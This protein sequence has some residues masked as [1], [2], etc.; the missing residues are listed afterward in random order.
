VSRSPGTRG[1]RLLPRILLTAG[2][3]VLL[4]VGVTAYFLK[5]GV[6]IDYVN[7]G[8][9]A[10][11]DCSLIWK[12]KLE[13]QVSEISARQMGRSTGNS[14]DINFVR[15]AIQGAHYLARLFSRFSIERLNLGSSHFT[16]DLRQQSRFTHV[17]TLSSD[18]LAFESLLTFNKETLDIDIINGRN[19]RF[20]TDFKGS[21]QLDG[22]NDRITGAIS[23]LINGS[24]PVSVD[25]VADNKELRFRGREAGEITEIGPLVDLFGLSHNIQRW[26]TEYLSGSRYQLLSF[27][28]RMPW[29]SPKE[30]L[31]TL[32]A[33]VRVDDTEYTFAPG[34]EPIKARYTNVYFQQGVLVI[35]PHDATFYGQDGGESWLDINFNDPQNILLTAYIKTRAVA[36][37]DILTLLDYYQIHLPFK[38]VEGKTAADLQLAIN[39]NKIQVEVEGFFEIDQG[40]IEW[41]AK[42]FQAEDARI[43]L[44]NSDVAIKRLTIG[45]G[46]IFTAQVAGTIQARDGTGDLDVIFDK[47]IL[48][49][50]GPRVGLDPSDPAKVRYRFDADGH[51]LE[52]QPS[53]WLLD[54]M[55]IKLQK[56]TG[57]VFLDDLAMD[58]A[59]VELSIESGIQAEISGYISLRKKEV[60]LVCDLLEYQVNDLELISSL[61]PIDIEY[62]KGLVIRTEA[63]SLWKMSQMPMTLYP[64]VFAYHDHE[65]RIERSRISYGSLFDSYLYGHYNTESKKGLFSLQEIDVTNV[66][67]YRELEL[68][69]NADVEVSGVGGKFV[70]YFPHFDLRITSDEYKN[71]SAEFG[72][73]STIYSRSE[74]LRKF[75]IKEGSL[76]VSSEYGA[77]PYRFSADITMPYPLLVE[78]GEPIER[79]KV[80]GR[81][82]DEG[83]F[84]TVSENLDIAYRDSHLALSSRRIGYNINAILE[85]LRDFPLA[86][87]PSAAQPQSKQPLLIELHAEDSQVYLSPQSRLLADVIKLKLVDGKV[88]AS[89]EHGPGQAQLQF[90]NGTFL[91][92]SSDLNDQFM[93]ALVKNSRFQ[94]GRMSMAASGSFDDFSIVFEVLDTNISGLA[95]VNNVMAFLNT[96]PALMTLSLPEYNTE[97]LPIDSAVAGMRFIEKVGTFESLKVKGPEL[98]VIGNG[99]LDFSRRLINMDIFIKTQASKNVGK[100]PLIGYVLTGDDEDA[101]LSLNISGGFDDPEVGNSLVQEIVVYPVEVL[102]RTL[103]LPFHLGEKFS[104]QPDEEPAEPDSEEIQEQMEEISIQDG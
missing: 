7:L 86:T 94:G 19:N 40:V 68:G 53:S 83:L 45:Y 42:N 2:L 22:Q 21:A 81:I 62:D 15:R 26:I 74:L 20:N 63:I 49:P 44:V 12:D 36:N 61:S 8:P 66:N 11:T 1:K 96:V 97:G 29:D 24:F 41:D 88:S 56:F 30:I 84:A 60:D 98:Q 89:L 76:S 27:K 37:D 101:S 59:P 72:D 28:G 50:E 87:G 18:D 47:L 52:A 43:D 35:K 25:I 34:L 90:E 82:A 79:V 73:L 17:L 46:D 4:G 69:R 9:I 13:L 16:V 102:F 57:P 23:A 31:S 67:L 14:A 5:R 77:R 48:K 85:L 55:P 104:A 39:L 3:L 91:L 33:E 70:A 58:V 93:G 80:A 10:I 65:F 103:K 38:Q 78:D 32:D 64:S 54:S 71:W 100:I 51:F 95:L 75:K 92:E 6:V 99:V